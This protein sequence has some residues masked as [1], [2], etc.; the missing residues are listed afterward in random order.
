M[1]SFTISKGSSLN[2]LVI[3]KEL[4]QSLK[5]FPR[6]KQQA[7]GGG[8]LKRV[9]PHF[10]GLGSF[11]LIQTVPHNSNREDILPAHTEEVVTERRQSVPPPCIRVR[12]NT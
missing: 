11:Y 3:T 6:E 2:N 5:M 12:I 4:G 7:G 10:Q 8:D 9:F 1:F